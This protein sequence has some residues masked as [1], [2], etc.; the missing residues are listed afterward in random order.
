MLDVTEP[1]VISD[2]DPLYKGDFPNIVTMWHEV[3]LFKA[4]QTLFDGII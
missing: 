3:S 1:P 4:I 2:F